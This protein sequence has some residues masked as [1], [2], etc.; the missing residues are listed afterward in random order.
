MYW[1]ERSQG[2]LGATPWEAQDLY[3]SNSPIFRADKITTPLL[4]MNNKQDGT[5]PFAQ[6]VEFFMALRRL[7]K[8]VWMLQYDGGYHSLDSRTKDAEDYTIRMMQFFDHYLKGAPA[9]KWMTRGIPANRKGID[10]GLQI[11]AEIKTPGE[12]LDKEKLY[13]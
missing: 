4:M 2:R 8:R 7:G 11:D 12:G 5:V 1:A 3:I 13:Q 6:G 9:P 10:D